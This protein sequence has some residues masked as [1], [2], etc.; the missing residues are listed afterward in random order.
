M[1]IMTMD[2]MLNVLHVYQVVLVV[3]T[4]YHVFR[5]GFQLQ[6]VFPPVVFALLDIIMMA[7]INVLNV[8]INVLLALMLLPATPALLVHQLE[9]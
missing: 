5:V 8:V 6:S 1:A 9:F 3:L 7:L 4:I 2:L